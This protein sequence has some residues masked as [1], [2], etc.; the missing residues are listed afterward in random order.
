MDKGNETSG[1]KIQE[2]QSQTKTYD[3]NRTDKGKHMRGYKA[4][5]MK[6]KWTKK[7]KETISSTM[8]N[9]LGPPVSMMRCARESSMPKSIDRCEHCKRLPAPPYPAHLS[10]LYNIV[11]QESTE[12]KGDEGKGSAAPHSDG[13]SVAKMLSSVFAIGHGV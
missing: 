1:I 11:V 7:H 10:E 9:K 8:K 6:W 4:S 3:E 2:H 13:W 5:V 12:S